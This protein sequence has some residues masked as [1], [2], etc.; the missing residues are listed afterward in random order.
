MA[1]LDED[2][3]RPACDDIKKNLPSSMEELK[4]MAKKQKAKRKVECPPRSA[5][6]GRSSWKLLHSMAAWYP[7]SPTPEQ[8]ETMKGFM[9]GL[10]AFYPCTWCATDFQENV[11]KTP[12]ATE[13]RT[14]LCM[15]LCDQ[16][17]RV[18]RKLGKPLFDC[19]M[20]DLD[21]RWRKSSNPKCQSDH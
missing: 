19:N 14:D 12:V 4:A 15:W 17:N 7:D 2:C 3:E 5:E 1:I 6:L 8:R 21:E 11:A 16:H 10:A 13:S 9:A 18:N 20:K